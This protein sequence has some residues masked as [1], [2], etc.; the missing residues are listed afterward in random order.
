MQN[1]QGFSYIME[2]TSYDSMLMS[3][4]YKTNMLNQSFRATWS[5]LKQQTTGR[6]N[7]MIINP[8]SGIL[9]ILSRSAVNKQWKV[10]CFS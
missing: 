7:C 2:R 10:S 4:L 1:E 5:S 6:Q 3:T 9:T 8:I